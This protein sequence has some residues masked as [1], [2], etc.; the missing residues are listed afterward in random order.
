MNIAL[1]GFLRN[2]LDAIPESRRDRATFAATLARL[3]ERLHRLK[4]RRSDGEAA[5]DAFFAHYTP[6]DPADL[7]WIVRNMA[8]RPTKACRQPGLYKFA[9][10]ELSGHLGELR[11]RK[12]E[13]QKVIDEFFALYLLDEQKDGGS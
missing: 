1:S 8:S 7:R 9:L 2:A 6:N 3:E 5:I 12:A 4:E 11:A 13:G 10:E